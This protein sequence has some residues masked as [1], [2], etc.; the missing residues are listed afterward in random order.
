[1]RKYFIDNMLL[2]A[3]RIFS[4]HF[5]D[6][7]GQVGILHRAVY[8]QENGTGQIKIWQGEIF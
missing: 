5:L 3:Y 7:G 4:F 1:M 2:L 6:D 8:L